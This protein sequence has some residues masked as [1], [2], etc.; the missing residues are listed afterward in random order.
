MGTAIWAG[1]TR[2][3]VE[4]GWWI[5]LS[6]APYVDYNLALIHGDDGPDV[7]PMVLDEVVRAD[8]PAMIMLAGAGLCAA[9]VLGDADWVCT[10]TLPFMARDYGPTED[11][12]HL[13]MLE[14]HEL[15]DARRLAAAAFG[16]P[17]EVGA[18]VYTEEALDRGDTR[19]WGLFE[20]DTLVCCSATQYVDGRYSVGWALATAPENQRAG[21]GRRLMRATSARRLAEGVPVAL[22][23]ATDAARHLYEQEG[24]ATL[25]HWQIWSRPRWVLR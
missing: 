10:G 22:L 18:I 8:V 21:L 3:Q 11:D 20:G 6:L 19:L 7:A 16:V 2:H 1:A 9:D 5:A 13:R 15:P 24:Y 14:R 23:T 4:D 12:P 25:E 17:D